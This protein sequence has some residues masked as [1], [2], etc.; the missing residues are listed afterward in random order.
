[1]R[2][3]QIK[4]ELEE[5]SSRG[6]YSRTP[7]KRRAIYS[8]KAVSQDDETCHLIWADLEEDPEEVETEEEEDEEAHVP[9]VCE[10]DED[11]FFEDE[12]PNWRIGNEIS[13]LNQARNDGASSSGARLPQETR[14]SR[15]SGP[16]ESHCDRLVEEREYE[17]ARLRK[18]LTKQQYVI[19]NQRQ[20]AVEYM[21]A[22][23]YQQKELLELREQMERMRVDQGTQE[24]GESSRGNKIRKRL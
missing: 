18:E 9:I 11:S 17:I 15:I 2:Q 5:G 7:K 21:E 22:I 14:S 23:L 1:M 20:N 19:D 6:E 16:C 12:I 8:E 10:N 4:Q 13:L 3:M 24:K